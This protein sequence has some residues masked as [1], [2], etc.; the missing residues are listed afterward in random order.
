MGVFHQARQELLA[1]RLGH[2]RVGDEDA[3][4]R[5]RGVLVE[6]VESFSGC[7]GALEDGALEKEFDVDAEAAAFGAYVLQQFFADREH[8][9]DGVCGC[10]CCHLVRGCCNYF[11]ISFRLRKGAQ[12]EKKWPNACKYHHAFGL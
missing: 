5:G 1:A 8:E 12:R 9:D 7:A 2:A 11:L 4:R 10:G 6:V 3:V